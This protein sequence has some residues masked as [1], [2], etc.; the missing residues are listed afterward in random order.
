MNQKLSRR[1]MLKGTAAGAAGL[2]ATAAGGATL[3]SAPRQDAVLIRWQQNEARWSPIVDAYNEQAAV[4]VEVEFINITGIDHE[5][6]A[7]KMLSQLASGQPFD[8][9]YAAT[10][11][12]QVYAGQGVAASLTERVLDDADE[13]QEFFDDVA[14]ILPETMLVEGDL[15]ELPEACNA[16]NLYLNVNLLNKVGLEMPPADWTK[17]DFHEYAKALTNVGGEETFGYNWVNRL[18]GGWGMWYFVNDSNILVEERAPGGEWFWETFYSENDTVA[19]RGGGFRWPAP[20]ANHPGVVEALE[21]VVSLTTDGLAP[22]IEMGGGRSLTG[23]FISDRLGMTPAGGFWAGGLHN[24]GMEYGAF[25]VQFWPAWKT[26]RHQLGVGGNW[27]FTG[28][29]NPDHMWEL[30]KFSIRREVQLYV[31]NRYRPVPTTTPARRS[32]ASEETYSISGPPNWKV[33]YDTLDRPDTGPIPA[34]PQANAITNIYT[35]YTGLAVSGE[36]SAQEAMD[37]AQAE[38]EALYA[39][40]S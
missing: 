11:A 9:G 36:M 7:S 15:Y 33:F 34:P 40:T 27:L 3:A 13:L 37:Q 23:L 10:E 26:Q 39:R 31:D 25:D 2:V 22:G 32:I 20:Q 1:E 30:F 5:E 17:D 12:T 28:S 16:P 29:P 24:D 6:V 19:H 35:R 18:W 21:F 8:G 14:P 38:M 4:P